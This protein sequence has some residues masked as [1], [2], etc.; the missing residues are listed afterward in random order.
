MQSIMISLVYKIT[1]YSIYKLFI[2][3]I[4]LR[5]WSFSIH[6]HARGLN[7]ISYNLLRVLGIFISIFNNLI[8]QKGMSSHFLNIVLTS[9]N[10]DFT[11]LITY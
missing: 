7:F 8:L 9:H 3:I 10:V 6:S 5:F 2:I 11:I 1:R 4:I